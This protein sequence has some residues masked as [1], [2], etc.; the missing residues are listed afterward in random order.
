[1]VKRLNYFDGQFLRATDFSA[2]Q[3]YHV[4]MRE[5][6][7]SLLHTWGIADGLLPTADGKQV[8]VGKG[9]AIDSLGRE[10]QL[11]NEVSKD[12]SAFAGKTPFITIKW[13]ETDADIST[14]TGTKGPKRKDL[15]PVIEVSTDTPEQGVQ[16]IL[17][18]VTLDANGQITTIDTSS[19]LRATAGAK[20]GDL[21]AV[22]LRLT[23]V[24][25]DASLQ[26]SLSVT[27][28]RRVDLYGSLRVQGDLGVTGNVGIGTVNPIQ[29]LD[30]SGGGIG[31]SGNNLNAADKRLYSP[32]DGDLEWMTNNSAGT[33]GF[34][35]SHQGT[36][37]VYLNTNGNSYLN[38]G[39]V[40][41]GTTTPQA[42]LDIAGNTANMTQAIF[43]RGADAAFQLYAANGT[44]NL[45]GAVQATFGLRYAGTGDAATLS[46]I[47]G[48][49]KTDASLAFNT[50]GKECLRITSAGK[51]VSPMWKL[52]HV[53]DQVQG[54]LPQ[55]AN[56]VS[57]GGTLMVIFSGS[58]R[59]YSKET[60]GM[61]LEI[62]G[63]FVA[64]AQSAT[65][66]I[67]S[68]KAFTTNIPVL[69]YYPPGVHQIVLSAFPTT[70]TDQSDFFSVTILE[71]PF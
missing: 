20:G 56:F 39:N 63:K 1:M 59:S 4:G 6:H 5:Q 48:G 54:G 41:I 21:S 61:K 43:T 3:S 2:E 67:D 32:A 23:G 25:L 70:V 64:N 55:S 40:G 66:E 46:F 60:I 35:I 34:A 31:F 33:H 58:G 38:G 17:G 36:K 22:S 69:P 30:V 13:S 49:G 28:A 68:H 29:K 9:F 57:G 10:I 19:T 51:L 26:P 15:S 62:D 16:L 37:A 50:N 65:N 7:N 71:L 14:E 52:S 18:T 44:N 45:D 24:N 12:I 42:T 27:T 47:R 53:M 11:D 8:K